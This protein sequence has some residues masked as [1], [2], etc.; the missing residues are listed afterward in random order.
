MNRKR[1]RNERDDEIMRHLKSYYKYIQVLKGNHEHHK[2]RNGRYRH[3]NKTAENQCLRKNIKSSLTGEKHVQR[4]KDKN[5][6][7]S[8]TIQA[9]KQWNDICVKRKKKVSLEFYIQ[10]KHL[11]EMRVK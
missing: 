5:S 9:R 11:S 2:E 4:S 10:Q 7:L 3:H 6:H 1:P 8:E